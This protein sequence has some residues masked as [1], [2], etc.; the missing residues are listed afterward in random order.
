MPVSELWLAT[1][2]A[3]PLFRADALSERDAARFAAMTNDARRRDFGVSRALAQHL[4][5]TDLPIGRRSHSAGHAAI[6]NWS[7]SRRAGVDLEIHTPRRFASLAHFGYAPAEAEALEARTG[8]NQLRLFY[9]L[10]TLKEAFAKALGMPLLA[11]LRECSFEVG[12]DALY[13]TIPGGAAWSA[14]VFEP[15]PGFSLAVAWL[16]TQAP[17]ALKLAQWPDMKAGRWHEPFAVAPAR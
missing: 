16:D 11:A 5:L 17:P 2:D 4:E 9:A 10:W 8:P 12:D 7:D 13:G 1:P 15:L 3:L 14:R 6:L